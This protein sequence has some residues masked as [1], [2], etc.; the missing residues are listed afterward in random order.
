[1]EYTGR[2]SR[3]SLVFSHLTW[4][5]MLNRDLFY[6]ISSLVKVRMF[7]WIGALL[8][9]KIKTPFRATGQIKLYCHNYASVYCL[10]DF[11][12]Q[13]IFVL[14][15]FNLYNKRYIS[16][17]A[18]VCIHVDII[19]KIVYNQWVIGISLSEWDIDQGEQNIN[20]T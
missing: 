13:E 8:F 14:I 2:N 5:P 18:P 1:M 7:L 12:L 19:F 6:S 9:H 11:L 16:F 4:A 3:T 20:H 17:H 10:P 15:F